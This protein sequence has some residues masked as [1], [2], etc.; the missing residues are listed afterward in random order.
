MKNRLLIYLLTFAMLSCSPAYVV[1][2]GWEEAGILW[3]RKDIGTL[4]EKGDLPEST[5]IKLR[6]A[7]NVRD[8]ANELGLTINHSYKYYSTVDRDDL[9]WVINAAKKS[10]LEPVSWWFPFV[11][12]VQYKG[13]FEKDDAQK[14]ADDF[15][16]DGYDVY[17]RSSPAF[18]TLGWFDDPLLSSIVKLDEVHIVNTILHELYHNSVWIADYVSFNESSANA[19]AWYA[20]EAYY[21]KASTL[22]LA[23]SKTAHDIWQE[24]LQFSDA[25]AELG[26]K[27]K[28]YYRSIENDKPANWEQEKQNFF[29]NQ[30]LKLQTTSPKLAKLIERMNNASL[31]ANMM[32][33]DNTRLMDHLYNQCNKEI[34]CWI[35]SITKITRL[36]KEKGSNPYDELK[37]WVRKY[38]I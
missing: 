11:G 9:V 1:R 8:Y 28:Q 22:N 33:L 10:S 34:T 15:A 20:T 23:H 3:R 35:E 29:L 14:A 38:E 12:S 6:T 4:L 37:D 2:A 13:Y 24:Q 17:L 36:A 5:A 27:L 31:L 32:Y 30:G 7:L 21:K 26:N 19:F 16:N 25:L 18:S